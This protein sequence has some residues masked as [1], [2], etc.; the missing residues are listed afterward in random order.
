MDFSDCLAVEQK[1]R[2]NNLAVEQM[3][4]HIKMNLKNSQN[5]GGEESA[6][7]YAFVFSALESCDIKRLSP[8]TYL[9]KLILSLHEK[10]VEK[11][12]LLPCYIRH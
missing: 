2:I 1:L 3:M 6:L 5:I 11:K 8:E 9:R 4:R 7:D 12:Q 10:K